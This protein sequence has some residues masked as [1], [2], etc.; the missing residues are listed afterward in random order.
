MKAKKAFSAV[1]SAAGFVRWIFFSAVNTDES[2]I[3]NFKVGHFGLF[4]LEC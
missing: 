4:F 1:I 3:D 2:F